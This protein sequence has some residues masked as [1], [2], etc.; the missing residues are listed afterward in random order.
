VARWQISNGGGSALVWS[1][2]GRELFFRSPNNRIMVAA[3]TVKGDS[4][5]GGGVNRQWRT[6][7]RELFYTSGNKLMT[8]DVK[9]GGT[10]N[11]L[12][13]TRREIEKLNC[14][15]PVCVARRSKIG[16]AIQHDK[17]GSIYGLDHVSFRTTVKG[18]FHTPLAPS[19]LAG[20]SHFPSG[21]SMGELPPFRVT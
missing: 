15:I 17:L 19:S 14:R 5:T 16:C 1:R 21:D 11:R 3:Q 9:L 18:I 7:G 2:N 10:A 12:D 20:Y 6:D 4:I 13:R 8:T